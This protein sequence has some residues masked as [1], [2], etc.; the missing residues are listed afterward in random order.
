MK[1]SAGQ[2]AVITGAASGIGLGL[3]EAL[4]A[5]GVGVV[6]SDV[7]EEALHETEERLRAQGAVVASV[8]TDVTD[9]DS[10][11]RLAARTVE[12]FGRVDLVCNNAGV[13]SPGLP[14]WEQDLATWS[15]M[16]DIKILGVVHGV[17]SFA[18]RLLEQGSGHFLNTAS[19]GGLA[20]LPS[21]SPYSATMHAVVG[22]TET[23]DLELRE[24][25]SGV[26]ATVLCPGL[27]DTPLGANSAALGVVAPMPALDPE[28]MRR[29]I[30]SQGGISTPRQVAESAI[31]AV[32][33][34]RVHA[35]PGGGVLA[36]ATRRAESL[37]A[38]IAHD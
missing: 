26:G 12:L 8:V 32:E 33:A 11:D 21:R 35:A 7:R 20:P 23:L 24:A 6:L 29:M 1:I 19:S 2:V 17:R 14:M 9:A 34:D 27:V 15:R 38:D 18:P 5:R 13:V 36:R 37:L 4:V 30:E 31:A 16:I 28:A 25:S 3:A 10:V 22:V